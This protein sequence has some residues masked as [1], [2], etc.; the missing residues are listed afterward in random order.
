MWAPSE[1]GGT[2]V[3]ICNP[4]E[5]ICTTT[6]STRAPGNA[7]TTRSSE[8]SAKMSAGGSLTGWV[9]GAASSSKKRRCL[10]SA[11]SRSAQASAHIQDFLRFMFIA[12]RLIDELSRSAD[13][14][15]QFKGKTGPDGGHRHACGLRFVLRGLAPVSEEIRLCGESPTRRVLRKL[16]CFARVHSCARACP[17]S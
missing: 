12:H 11:S 17:P 3:S 16:S 5:V 9:E 14:L 4:D 7:T 13:I 1:G 10:R 15:A 2:V 6:S 8:P